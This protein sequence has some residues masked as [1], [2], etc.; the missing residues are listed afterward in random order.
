M[1]TNS[2]LQKF[3]Q[4]FDL[5]HRTLSLNGKNVDVFFLDTMCS[6]DKVT[7]FVVRP[8]IEMKEPL[9][10]ESLVEKI[11]FGADCKTESDFDKVCD[12][13]LD[14]KTIVFVEKEND[15]VIVD[16]KTIEYRAV[17]EPP[18]SRSTKGP[19]EG[20]NEN[21]KTN[22][23]LLRKRLKTENFKADSFTVGDKTNTMV[24]VCY[25]KGTAS[26]KIVKSITEKI[27]TIKTDGVL[28]SSFVA[29]YLDADKTTLFKLVGS[30]EKPDVVASKLLEGKVA[31]IVDGSPIVLT[32][33]YTFLE[34]V[35]SPDD[36]YYYTPY[37]ASLGRVL[38]LISMI[39]AVLL[40]AVYV[41][42]Q[43]F[44]YQI[45][46]SKF[47]ITVLSSVQGIP[48]TPLVEM[49]VV[50]ILFDI[51]REA[52]ARM[53]QIAGLSLSIV[54]AIILGDAAVKAGLLGAPAVMIG[55]MSGIG[56]YSMPD[57]TM[58]FSF[59][60]L[61]F[62]LIGGLVGILGILLGVMFVVSY[63]VSIDDFGTPY[64]SPLSP[65]VK[66]DKKD[67]ILRKS[68]IDLNQKSNADLSLRGKETKQ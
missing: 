18:T 11:I 63:V 8:L 12:E 19:R 7:Q 50:I 29:V 55:A 21:I 23:T 28:D 62:V 10:A 3:S 27:K 54:G 2:F 53:P 40:P 26:D 38:R 47:L 30:F 33:P 66:K 13:F 48:F 15:A 45:L 68:L 43:L 25:I 36:Y 14:G 16:T 20:F 60:R 24:A 51:L 32:L 61:C 49:I 39:I 57:N 52:N 37:T 42:L 58:L 46:P 59:L 31:V 35:Q 5:K 56:L 41:A 34:D 6:S 22:L 17:A 67:A 44:H 1:D 65:S 64:L 4:F 9:S